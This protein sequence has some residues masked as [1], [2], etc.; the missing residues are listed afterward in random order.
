MFGL[1]N[2][3]ETT[4]FERGPI[5]LYGGWLEIITTFCEK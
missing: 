3:L 4:Y 5:L 2:P 1:P